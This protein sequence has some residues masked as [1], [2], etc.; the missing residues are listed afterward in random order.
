MILVGLLSIH[1]SRLLSEFMKEGIFL[2]R[3]F[4]SRFFF[5]E[6]LKILKNTRNLRFFHEKF[7]HGGFL[8]FQKTA[9]LNESSMGKLFGP[10]GV[11][12]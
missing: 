9:R 3:F 2:D 7:N 5:G 11:S 4:F 10:Q 12:T 1:H 8:S 6:V